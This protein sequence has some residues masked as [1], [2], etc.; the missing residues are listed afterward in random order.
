MNTEEAI[1]NIKSVYCEILLDLFDETKAKALQKERDDIIALLQQGEKAEEENIVLKKYKQM[2]EGFKKIY[3]SRYI[4]YENI[5]YQK[6]ISW[7]MKFIEQKY[8]PE[9]K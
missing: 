6:T 1:D 7:A 3:G 8:F 5:N 4:H 2:W 9:R